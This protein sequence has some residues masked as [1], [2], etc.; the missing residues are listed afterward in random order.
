MRCLRYTIKL[1]QSLENKNMLCS[2]FM[3][4]VRTTVT[5][6]KGRFLVYKIAAF[7]DCRKVYVLRHKYPVFLGTKRTAPPKDRGSSFA[8]N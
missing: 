2:F 6:V 1:F 4:K 5:S 8:L 7:F 3:T